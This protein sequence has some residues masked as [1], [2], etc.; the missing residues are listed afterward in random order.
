[1]TRH[2]DECG[3]PCCATVWLGLGHD[4]NRFSSIR[5]NGVARRLGTGTPCWTCRR[6]ARRL[7]RDRCGARHRVPRSP[8]TAERRHRRERRRLC[9]NTAARHLLRIGSAPWRFEA[10]STCGSL[11][12]SRQRCSCLELPPALTGRAASVSQSKRLLVVDSGY[13]AMRERFS[14]TAPNWAVDRSAWMSIPP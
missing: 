6:S 4:S 7:A 11:P 5:T 2:A 1:M 13:Q 10:A 9:C 14:G 8:G 12:F 3:G